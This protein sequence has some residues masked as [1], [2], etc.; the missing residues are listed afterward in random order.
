MPE[1]P[2]KVAVI[3]VGHLGSIHA[4][5][6]SEYPGAELVGVVDH[7]LERARALAEV[8]GQDA[9]EVAGAITAN[10]VRAYRLDI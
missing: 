2:L 6:Y 8:R 10:A 9:A 4:K 5:I 1:T 3:G 7:D